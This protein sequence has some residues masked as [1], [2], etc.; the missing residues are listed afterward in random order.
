MGVRLIDAGA[1]SGLGL[2]VAFT[3]P[4]LALGAALALAIP[5]RRRRVRR[6]DERRHAEQLRWRDSG[7]LPVR[8]ETMYWPDEA[9]DE[10]MARMHE[11]GYY[12]ADDVVFPGGR[13]RVVYRLAGVS[14]L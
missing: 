5:L 2:A 7:Q 4:L 14:A 9:V 3:W 8:Y 6:R 10:D 13:R 12:V 11:L 1:A